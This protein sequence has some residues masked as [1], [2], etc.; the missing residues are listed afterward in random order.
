MRIPIGLQVVALFLIAGLPVA[1]LFG[2]RTAPEPGPQPILLSPS[3]SRVTLIEAPR[4]LAG[5]APPARL[6]ELERGNSYILTLVPR[7]EGDDDAPPYRLRVEG[8]DGRVVLVRDYGE[9]LAPDAQLQI[10]L[11]VGVAR[12]GRNA[13]VVTDANGIVRSYPFI[14]P[15]VAPR[16]TRTGS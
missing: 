13:V 2:R 12:S 4:G 16:N 14:V 9:S 5:G 11:P 10:V 7:R 3:D 8:P 15:D 6:P 1:W